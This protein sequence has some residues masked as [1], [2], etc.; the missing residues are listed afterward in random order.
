MRLISEDMRKQAVTTAVMKEMDRRSIHEYGLPGAV[1]MENAGACVAEAAV[2]GVLPVDGSVLVMAGAGNN[3]GDGFVAARYLANRG[4]QVRVVTAVEES[5][6]SEDAAMY[7]AVIKK[8]GIEITRWRDGQHVDKGDVGAILDSLL[9]TGLSGPLRAPYDQMIQAVN[10]ADAP[11]VAVDIPSG[12]NG[13]TGEVATVAVKAHTTVT[14]ALP[15]A[16]LYLGEGPW[17]A[18]RIIVGDIEMPRSVYPS[19]ASAEPR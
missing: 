1:L 10:E 2:Q 19:G 6:C 8:M 12:L 14:F 4:F 3:A 17:L 11:V 9:G 13:D 16:G 18:G 7:L 5:A 15:K